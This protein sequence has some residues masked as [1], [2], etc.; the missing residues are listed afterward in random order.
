MKSQEIK[1]LNV[2]GHDAN[3][4]HE[5]RLTLLREIAYQLAVANEFNAAKKDEK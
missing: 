4:G 3:T 2:R 1:E 5:A